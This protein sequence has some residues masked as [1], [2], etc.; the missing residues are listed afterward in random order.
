[1][2]QNK[3]TNHKTFKTSF[4]LNWFPTT[5]NNFKKIQ[6]IPNT[7]VR[8]EYHEVSN[9]DQHPTLI[10]N[11]HNCTHKKDAHKS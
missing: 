9:V 7:K 10:K 6:K 5:N 4:T 11:K 1:M 3:Q 8:F 2:H